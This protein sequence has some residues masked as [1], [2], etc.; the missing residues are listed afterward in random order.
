M[1][2]LSD[3]ENIIS[4][5]NSSQQPYGLKDQTFARA[6]PRIFDSG[7]SFQTLEDYEQERSKLFE[8]L[9]RRDVELSKTRHALQTTTRAY[10]D[11]N[12]QMKIRL[13]EIVYLTK[14]I[15]IAEDR[16]E[17]L[18]ASM[19]WKITAPARKIINFLRRMKE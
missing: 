5:Y 1:D 10:D 14:R 17:A 8:S 18:T 13:D 15:I 2:Q 19:S 16:V 4:N 11:L 9:M 6:Q 7:N 12:A 3:K